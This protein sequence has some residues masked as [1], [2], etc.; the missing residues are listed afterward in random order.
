VSAPLAPL[1]LAAALVLASP[2]GAACYADYKAKQDNPLR[3]HYGV[4]EVP[5][6]A[7]SPGAAQRVV[8]R[9]LAA[10]GWTLLNVMSVFGPE[11]LGERQASAGEHFLRY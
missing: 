1:A 9:R 8:A 2:A 7:C 5:D 10:A 3:L 11:G 6:S 4:I